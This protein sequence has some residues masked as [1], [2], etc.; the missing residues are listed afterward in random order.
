MSRSLVD[1]NEKNIAV[2]LRLMSITFQYIVEIRWNYL[3]SL[4]SNLREIDQGGEE[5]CNERYVCMS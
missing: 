4:P 1:R 2:N 5:Q 3:S